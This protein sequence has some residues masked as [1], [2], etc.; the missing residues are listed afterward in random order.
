M[1]I[2]QNIG[3]KVSRE[4]E[5]KDMERML[6]DAPE[7]VMLCHRPCGFHTNGAKTLAHC[8]VDQEDPLRFFV[9]DDGTI[10]YNPIIHESQKLVNSDEGCM[11]FAHKTTLRRVQR[12]RELLVSYKSIPEGEH[13]K[14]YIEREL[15][16]IFQHEIDHMDGKH[17]W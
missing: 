13:D 10:I 3:D 16:F 9:L 12:H 15:A 1:K 11:S 7:M 6:T 17:I 2:L 8:Q 14:E 4:V 5:E